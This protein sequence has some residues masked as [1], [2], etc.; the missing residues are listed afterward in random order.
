M[1]HKTSSTATAPIYL[2]ADPPP[3][4]RGNDAKAEKADETVY[5]CMRTRR[6]V[7]DLGYSRMGRERKNKTHRNA[8]AETLAGHPLSHSLA[9]SPSFPSSVHT[10]THK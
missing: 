2:P 9:R 6:K 3:L 5:R 8:A 7:A 1:G 10:H 4:E